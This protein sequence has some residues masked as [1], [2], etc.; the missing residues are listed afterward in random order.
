V[1]LLVG[2]R[3]VALGFRDWRVPIGPSFLV[4]TIALAGETIVGAA[5]PHDWGPTLIVLVPLCFLASLASRAGSVWT[6][7][8]A[9]DLSRTERELELRHTLAFTAWIPV[10][11]VGAVLLGVRGGLLDRLG[12]ILSPAGDALAS[13]LVFV[14][15][16]LS[17]PLF[18]LA[19]RMHIDPNGVRRLLARVG[20]RA[21]HARRGALHQ[22]G[23]PSFVARLVGLGAFS[24]LVWGIARLMRRLR[25]EPQSSPA[26]DQ[27]S[28]A[29][30]DRR[31]I[32]PTNVA[33]LWRRAGLEPPSDRVRRWYGEALAALAA[34]G[35]AKDDAAT[36]AEFAPEVAIAYP[37]CAEGFVALTRAYEDVRYG[38]MHFDRPA[39]RRLEDGQHRLLQAVRRRPPDHRTSEPS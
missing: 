16:Q 29:A 8:D 36:P 2:W 11:M 24:F 4:C 20:N 34:R 31:E 27:A 38:S 19:D 37:E 17:R 9:G 28:T 23:H 14:F 13:L 7:V 32:E 18:W 10:A 21:R 15:S 26:V 35:L 25:S 33:P 1:F 6:G 39:L 5:A 22:I 12:S 30:V 3:A